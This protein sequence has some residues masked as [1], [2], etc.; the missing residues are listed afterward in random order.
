LFGLGN[1][2]ALPSLQNLVLKFTPMENRAVAMTAFSATI[3]VGQTIGPFI[4]SLIALYSIEYVFLFPA[5]IFGLLLISY[6]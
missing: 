1:G 2:L 3:R 6:R 4:T 5:I